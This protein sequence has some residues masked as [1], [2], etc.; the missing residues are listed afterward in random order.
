MLRVLGGSL[1]TDSVAPSFEQMGLSV[2]Q[3]IAECSGDGK[4]TPGKGLFALSDCES[5]NIYLGT[6]QSPDC[7]CRK[8]RSNYG[9]QQNATG[10]AITVAS[11]TRHVLQQILAKVLLV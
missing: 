1:D 8:P 3:A 4:F 2:Q 10:A 5:E 11:A 6:T 9:L 7:L